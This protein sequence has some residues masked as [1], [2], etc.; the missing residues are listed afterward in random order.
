[1]PPVT[2]PTSAGRRRGSRSTSSRSRPSTP[3]DA[4]QSVL[5]AAPDRVGQDGGGGVRGRRGRWPRAARRSTPRRSRRCRTR[6]TA[7]S[8]AA[9]APRRVGLLTGDNSINGDA[10][11]VVMT[12]EVLRNMIY[13]ALAGA[14]RAC[15]TSCSTRC[16]TCR[17]PY[18]G[19]VWEEVIIHLRPR[20]T[21]CACRPRCRTPRSSPT[22]S[23]TVRGRRPRSSRS[24]GPVELRNLYLRRR[25]V[26]RRLL[27]LPT[28]VDGRPEPGGRPRWIADR[29][30]PPGT[31]GRPPPAAVHAAP[32]RGRRAPGRR[33]H[34]AGHLLHLQPGRL[35]RRRAP[36]RRRRPAAHRP[37]EERER[38]PRHRRGHVEALSRRR[39]RVLGYGRVARRAGGRASPPTTPG[40]VPPFKEA[41]EAVLR[42]R[43]GQGGVRHRDARRS[44]STCRPGSVVIE[45]LTKFTG[46]RH[47]FLT[48]GEY[49]QLTGRA[50]R[51]GIDDLGYA[52]V[53]W[54][55]FVPVR[56]G[57]RPGVDP[58]PTRSTSAFRP[59]YNMAAN[60]VRR[61]PPEGPPPAQ[62]VVRPVPGRPRRRPA[63]GPARRD[64]QALRP[65][66]PRRRCE[67]GDVEEYRGL[68]ARPSEAR[69]AAPVGDGATVVDALAR[70]AARRRAR[71]AGGQG[72]GRVAVVSTA[73]RRGG[74]LRLRA[75]T[76]E[77]RRPDPLGPTTSPPRPGRRRRSSCPTRTARTA[78][79]SSARWPS[80]AARRPSARR[81]RRRRRH[82]AGDGATLRPQA[83][84]RRHPVA[85]C[86]DARAHLRGAGAGRAPRGATPT[87][88]SGRIRGRTET[89]ARQFD[90]V[91]RV[92]EAW[93]YVDGWALTDAGRA[94]GAPLPRVRPADRRVRCGSGL[95]DGLDPAV[96]RRAGL[97]VHLRG[98]RPA[99][100][101]PRR[102]SRRRRLRERWAA[103][104]AIWPPSSTT[105]RTRPGCRS[106][107]A[108]RRVRR[109]SRTPG[110]PARSSTTS[111]PTRR[112]RA[113]TSCATSSS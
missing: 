95:L 100:A 40:M 11:V 28:F 70:I 74:E 7:T 26:A 42:R 97:D 82:R 62:P 64:R 35:R 67:R 86:P 15:A 52:V 24:A 23:T 87:G 59:T 55:P 78:R 109:R 53:L 14:R 25:Q 41:V 30:R 12:T 8:C 6:S 63:R 5:V 22:G 3:L 113:A 32:H 106:P 36:C 92:L 112:S 50:G 101:A 57:G 89:L 48:P 71:G 56:P 91:L 58:R 103:I 61:Y 96:G 105:P 66:R 72:G 85:A 37:A 110:R 45:K 47:E 43:A 93:G 73:G 102:G 46:E 75:V 83:A 1:M 99:E 65:R 31:R 49:T 13:A 108:R 69:P 18:R 29:W 68:A 21:S 20:S 4:G 2:D 81:R 98:P 76:A 17:T 44:A 54:S 77:R 39:P 34:A 94:S 9:T 80:R 27:L 33:G 60:L 79:R 104:E 10:P 90:R 88:S 51:R 111:S 107:A 19:P 38:D 84:R 16:T